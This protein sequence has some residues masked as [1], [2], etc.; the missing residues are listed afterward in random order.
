MASFS[1]VPATLDVENF[2]TVLLNYWRESHAF[3]TTPNLIT[4]GCF[5]KVPNGAEA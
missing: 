3:F 1:S 5:A 4:I 2:L